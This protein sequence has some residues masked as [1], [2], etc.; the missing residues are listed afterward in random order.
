[1]FG[2]GN[3]L[4]SGCLSPGLAPAEAEGGELSGFGDDDDATSD[5]FDADGDGYT[6]AAAG[7]DDCVDS[8]PGI[9]PGAAEIPCNGVDEDCDGIADDGDAVVVELP[10]DHQFDTSNVRLAYDDANDRLLAL[11]G[12]QEGIFLVEFD[13]ALQVTSFTDLSPHSDTIATYM[14]LELE[15]DGTPHV[16]FFDYANLELHYMRAEDPDATAWDEQ[17]WTDNWEAMAY[18]RMC[19]QDGEAD[20]AYIAYWASGEDTAS[21][22]YKVPSGNSWTT[23]RLNT[24]SLYLGLDME[25]FNSGYR[26]FG[27]TWVNGSDVELRTRNF[28]PSDAFSGS[29]TA[30][31][32]AGW[33]LEMAATLGADKLALI[34]DDYEHDYVNLMWWDG[35]DWEGPG[36]MNGTSADIAYHN[37]AMVDDDGLVHM[38]LVHEGD[39]YYM[40]LSDYDSGDTPY[41]D[42]MGDWEYAAVTAAD[43][44]TAYLAYGDGDTLKFVA[45]CE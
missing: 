6:D 9:H 44:G 13:R 10:A 43:D 8:D 37:D 42:G 25:C 40:T 23:H 38:A 4:G 39:L 18:V 34:Y 35:D 32:S 36:A 28:N 26:Y 15:F 3:L 2:V 30:D 33:H 17:Y 14:D 41:T 21:I 12:G 24:T 27:Y 11:Y 29:V 22:E 1:M 5:P 16:A 45:L 31:T 19:V 20:L 7:G